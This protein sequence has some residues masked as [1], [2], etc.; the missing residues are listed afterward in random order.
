MYT[1]IYIHI[2]P[3]TYAYIYI[4]TYTYMYIHTYI[5]ACMHACMHTYIHTYIH[6]F[7]MMYI[8]IYIERER[9][10]VKLCVYRH[11]YSCNVYIYIYVYSGAQEQLICIRKQM[12]ECVLG[13]D[14]APRGIIVIIIIIITT[15]SIMNVIM[16]IIVIIRSSSSSNFA[17]DFFRLLFNVLGK[18]MKVKE[19]D[20][21]NPVWKKRNL[22]Y[23][24]NSRNIPLEKSPVWNKFKEDQPHG[25]KAPAKNITQLASGIIIKLS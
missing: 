5:H 19:K 24:T 17:G 8:Y 25:R 16:F 12:I 9:Y 13:T 4:H 18:C 23:G 10:V 3:Y 22:Q 15:I 20:G 1:N 14:M 11:V 2:H 7:A 21:T 6:I